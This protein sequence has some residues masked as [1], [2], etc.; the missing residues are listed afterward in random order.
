MVVHSELA[1]IASRTVVAALGFEKV[2]DQAV[3]LSAIFGFV[4]IKAPED[5]RRAGLRK[6][7]G[8]KAPDEQEDGKMY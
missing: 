6:H 1:F 7:R 2:A 8:D 5:R 4:E 3:S